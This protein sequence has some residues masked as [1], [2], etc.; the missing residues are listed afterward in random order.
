VIAVGLPS[1][2]LR[3]YFGSVTTAGVLSAAKQPIDPQQA[4]LP[5]WICTHQLVS[6]PVMWPQL[7]L[8]A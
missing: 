6:W 3:H 8:Y 1:S 5:V 7:R 4:G 2:E